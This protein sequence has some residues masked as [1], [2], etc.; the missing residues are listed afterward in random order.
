MAADLKPAQAADRA[1]ELRADEADA[2][3]RAWWRRVPR[4]VTAPRPVF[5]A[6]AETDELDVG[7]RSE[8][9]LAITILAGTAAVLLTPVW[10]QVMDDSSVDGLVVA[11]VTFVAGLFYGAVGYFLLGLTMWLG[12]KAV[13]VD[14]PFRIA[15]QLV[16][17]AAL[18]LALSLAVL[19][20]LIVVWFGEDWFRDGGSDEGTGRAVVLGIGLAFALWSLG[21]LVVGLRATFR[22]PWQGVAGA[23]GLAIVMVAAVFVLSSELQDDDRQREP[24]APTAAL[25]ASS[26]SSAIP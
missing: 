10:G 15:R 11:V 4:I 17:L 12:T 20:P 26:S 1:A 3:G 23:L 21:L 7:A 9:I 6:L 18:P 2:L 19:V 25:K 5:E 22:L 16:G 13:G 8:P 24:A 14:A